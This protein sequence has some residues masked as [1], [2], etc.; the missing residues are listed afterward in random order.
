MRLDEVPPLGAH[1]V[2]GLQVGRREVQEDGGEDVGHVQQEQVVELHRRKDIPPAP[3]SSS[4]SIC[5]CCLHRGVMQS[6]K[7]RNL[8][9][10]KTQNLEIKMIAYLT[11]FICTVHVQLSHSDLDVISTDF[12]T[13]I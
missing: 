13:D 4:A 6:F 1:D 5:T 10:K 7:G 11:D 12:T 9:A 2:G 8:L 3:P